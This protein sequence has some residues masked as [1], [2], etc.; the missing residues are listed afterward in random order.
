MDAHVGLVEAIEVGGGGGEHRLRRVQRAA[1][2]APL[3]HRL[4][5]IGGIPDLATLLDGQGRGG[6]IKKSLKK[7]RST[8]LICVHNRGLYS[9][10]FIQQSV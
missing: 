6:G 2:L 1:D 5:V 4:R 10:D 8:F 7:A 3:A 9:K